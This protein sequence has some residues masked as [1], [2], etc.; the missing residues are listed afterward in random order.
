MVPTFLHAAEGQR[1][2]VASRVAIGLA[3][4]EALDCARCQAMYIVMAAAAG[5]EPSRVVEARRGMANGDP[6]E[7]ARLRFALAV[8]GRRGR[9]DPS[10][11]SSALAAGL[12]EAELVEVVA[13]VARKAFTVCLRIHGAWPRSPFTADL[14]EPAA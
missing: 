8:L 4:S 6:L 1:L 10:E 9:P 3:V 13:V 11:L 12:D 2:S 7:Q 5:L 14:P